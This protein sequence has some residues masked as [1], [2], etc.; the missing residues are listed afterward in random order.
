MPFADP[1]MPYV[2]WARLTL[3]ESGLPPRAWQLCDHLLLLVMRGEGA[4][5]IGEH[6]V[7]MLPDRL[8]LLTPGTWYSFASTTFEQLEYLAVHFDW[9]VASDS[10]RYPMRRGADEAEVALRSPICF[11]H[12][13]PAI[14]PF[15]DLRGR[16]RVIL[17]LSSLVAAFG[18]W[19]GLSP[20]ETG[21]L[22][23]AALAQIE[24]EAQ[25]IATVAAYEHVGA[26][27]I[28]RVDQARE[29]LESQH[30][31]PLRITDV[32]DSV[33]WSAD[34]LRR[35][36]RIVLGTAP[37]DVQ[38]AAMIRR[39]KHLLANQPLPVS[40]IAALCG[41]D[42]PTHFSRVFKSETGRSPVRYR[43]DARHEES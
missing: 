25:L 27:A 28:R 38:R 43:A 35:M 39:A 5:R 13:N 7:E 8:F 29:L 1:T 34:H 37:F 9:H 32:A 30:A 23:A 14:E 36:F 16:P 33:G 41:Y 15:L 18:R 19:D 40:E 4:V 3:A 17:A 24:R 31:A 6:S 11:P 10:A 22:L 20:Y 42:D 2:R 21:A 26:D 12:W